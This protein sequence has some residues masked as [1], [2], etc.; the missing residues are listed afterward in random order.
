MPMMQ[1]QCFP[2][3]TIAQIERIAKRNELSVHVLLHRDE[4]LSKIVWK[5]LKIFELNL[6]FHIDTKISAFTGN[7]AWLQDSALLLPQHINRAPG[8]GEI[9]K[10]ISLG[11]LCLLFSNRYHNRLWVPCLKPAFPSWSNT[12]YALHER[13]K[14]LVRVRNRIA[15]HE[16]IYNYPLIEIVDFA[17]QI[18]VD[19]NPIAAEELRKR[20]YAASINKIRLGSGGGI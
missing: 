4:L 19:V 6:R 9:H 16:I 17:Q 18:L 3:A 15:H 10:S 11:Y 1:I 8:R 12:R 7:K 20:N 2:S 14:I 13:F 5:Q